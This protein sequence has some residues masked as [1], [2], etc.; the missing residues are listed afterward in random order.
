MHDQLRQSHLIGL[1]DALV[2]TETVEQF[3]REVATLAAPIADDGLSCAMAL[4]SQGRRVAAAAC[5]GQAAAELDDLQAVEGDGPGLRAARR[6]EMVRI[7]D[8]GHHDRWR[9]FARRALAAGIRSSLSVP[10]TAEGRPAGALSLYARRPHAFGPEATRNAQWFASQA[11]GALTLALRMASCSDLNEQLRSSMASR[12][13]IDQALGVIMVTDRCP[14]DRALAKLKRASQ[15]TN[16][17]IRDLAARIVTDA[18][19]Q[20]PQPPRPFEEE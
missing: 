8:V 18:S 17:K 1:Q 20:A 5:T 6:G 13:I 3:L 16:V 10:L 9:R 14:H 15:N 2:K 19:G 11:S 4:P 12:A 7:D